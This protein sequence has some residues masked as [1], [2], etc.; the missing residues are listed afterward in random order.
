MTKFSAF[1]RHGIFQQ[2][3]SYSGTSWTRAVAG[4]T[5]LLYWRI[6]VNRH[7][8]FELYSPYTHSWSNHSTFDEAV[9]AADA[10]I[11]GATGEPKG[12]PHETPV[13]EKRL[14]VAIRSSGDGCRL[15][16]LTDV[17][18]QSADFLIDIPFENYNQ[19]LYFEMLAARWNAFLA[20]KETKKPDTWSR[21]SST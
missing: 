7:G 9:A 1:D 12:D 6:V 8:R 21:I 2:D 3:K 18:P 10:Q 16:L 14:I 11:D 19:L 5:S 15:L 13:S 20:N 17:Y 4:G